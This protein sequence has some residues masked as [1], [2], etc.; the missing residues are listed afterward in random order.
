MDLNL[1]SLS[2]FEDGVP[3]VLNRHGKSSNSDDYIITR[4]P[5]TVA[6]LTTDY[7]FPG[8]KS[9]QL[10]PFCNSLV[11]TI[12]PFLEIFF[13]FLNRVLFEHFR[14]DFYFI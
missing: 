4:P 6:R 8:F 14:R 11:K 12:L 1:F 3:E 13:A 9:L 5:N 10:Q 7:L 2:K